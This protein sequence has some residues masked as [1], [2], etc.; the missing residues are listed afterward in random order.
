MYSVA[1]FRLPP[2]IASPVPAG[3]ADRV[4]LNADRRVVK[5][6][7]ESPW[8]PAARSRGRLLRR[9]FRSSKTPHGFDLVFVQG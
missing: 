3:S 8:S 1:A 9:G 7:I 5:P 6:A 2:R 4:G